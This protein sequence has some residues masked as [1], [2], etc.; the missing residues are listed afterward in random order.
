MISA[1]YN[2][3]SGINSYSK[4]L[5]V[6]ANNIANVNT[7]GYKADSMQFS[8]MMYDSSN[9][10]GAGSIGNGVGTFEVQK[11]FDQGELKQSN[12]YYDF[13]IDGKGFFIV[14]DVENDDT[15]YLRN[16]SFQKS[17]TGYLVD[18]NG[19][20]VLGSATQISSVTSSNDLTSF[21]E[22]YVRFIASEIVGTQDFTMSVNARAT[23]FY[24]TATDVGT[25]GTNYKTAGTLLAD[26][27]NLISNY[28][29]KLGEYE[30]DPNVTAVESTN[31]QVLVEYGSWATDLVSDNSYLEI[32]IG[33]SSYRQQ[34]ETD[35]LTTMQ[36]FAD[37]I[38][39]LIG[40]SASFDDTTGIL[41]IDNLVPGENTP[42][43]VPLGGYTAPTVTTTAAVE[44]AGLGL[45]T[46]A[47]DALKDM[48]ELA[49]GEFIDIQNTI[50]A[51]NQETISLDTLDLKLDTLGFYTSRAEVEA[52]VDTTF[53]ADWA[54]YALDNSLDAT[55]ET[56]KSNYYER[57]V[58]EKLTVTTD[59]EFEATDDGILL[60]K[61]GQN[62]YIIGRLSTAYFADPITL[63]PVGSNLYEE[64]VES[65]IPKNADLINTVYTKFLE[66]SN[67]NLAVGFSAVLNSQRAFEANAKAITTSD[68]FLKT[69]INLK[70]S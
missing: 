51:P 60:V 65:G 2:G 43:D 55:D 30:S 21:D 7:T 61:E 14:N 38:S 16:G 41:T 67:T 57:K 39:N 48:I 56:L 58:T 18:S 53:E 40:Y 37:K 20:N 59:A 13:A 11:D 34:F 22:D 68:E 69:A 49:G 54:T 52:I 4:G 32:Y 15:Y 31:Q 26:I 63:N 46:S 42:I 12:T 35:A 64:T 27:E 8:R 25:S 24:E 33:S 66:M 10:A 6:V 9:T 19:F 28:S 44:G 17:D 3:L 5:N 23:D 70:N 50:P 36:L 1:L 29:S 62:T 45:V 47:R